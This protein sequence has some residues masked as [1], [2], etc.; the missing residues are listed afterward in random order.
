MCASC[1][2]MRT[3]IRLRHVIFTGMR[4]P[5]ADFQT[6]TYFLTLI[7]IVGQK[8]HLYSWRQHEE[9]EIGL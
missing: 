7:G 4:F 5:V 3:A 9:D 1:S 2:A 8:E 6:E